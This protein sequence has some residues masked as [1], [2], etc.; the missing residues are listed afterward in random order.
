MKTTTGDFDLRHD[1]TLAA[2]PAD[3]DVAR[4]SKIQTLVSFAVGTLVVVHRID[5]GRDAIHR[6]T[7][8]GIRR[9]VE[10]TV[11]TNT[12]KGPLVVSVGHARI[13]IGRTTAGR[14]HGTPRT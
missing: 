8:L 6:L 9:G 10:L 12:G 5:A 3:H 7:G 2:A 11:Q 14:I 13:A 4:A 1:G